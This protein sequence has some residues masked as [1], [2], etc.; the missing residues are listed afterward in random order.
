M[1]KFE[2]VYRATIHLAVLHTSM[3][4]ILHTY[5][6]LCTLELLEEPFSDMGL[7]GIWSQTYFSVFQSASRILDVVA[8]TKN[9]VYLLSKTDCVPCI[10]MYTVHFG[11]IRS[12]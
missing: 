7:V 9:T 11:H 6:T 3:L 12:P 4:C 2:W 8:I 1:Y 10:Y 5:L